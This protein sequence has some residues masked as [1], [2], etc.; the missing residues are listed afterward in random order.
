VAPQ[1]CSLVVHGDRDRLVPYPCGVHTYTV[2]RSGLLCASPVASADNA[3]GTGTGG[4]CEYVSSEH[5]VSTLAAAR[6]EPRTATVTTHRAVPLATPG[7]SAGSASASASASAS[8]STVVE[9]EIRPGVT[10]STVPAETTVSWLETASPVASPVTSPT[11]GHTADG[12]TAN[13]S[14]GYC[15][16]VTVPRGA[17]DL[18]DGFVNV[19]V[20]ALLAH[21]RDADAR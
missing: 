4:E 17:H 10:V 21:F 20:P 15:R 12:A 2:L 1:L 5:V 13:T 8:E 9:V 6:G 3:A 19:M 14:T 18:N 7:P 11:N 16:L